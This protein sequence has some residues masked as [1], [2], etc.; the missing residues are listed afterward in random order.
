MSSSAASSSI[1]SGMGRSWKSADGTATAE[2]WPPGSAPEPKT[3]GPSMQ[4][5]GSPVAHPS[6]YPQPATDAVSTRSPGRKR[7]TSGPT[8][9]TVPTNSWP[10]AIPSPTGMSP[11]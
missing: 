5:T 4:V 3:L 2:A 7:R 6:Q 11:S 9:A 10:T 8:S 1:P